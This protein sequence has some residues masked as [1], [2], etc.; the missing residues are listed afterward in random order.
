M[1]TIAGLTVH[2]F[3]NYCCYV[4]CVHVSNFKTGLLSFSKA[5]SNWYFGIWQVPVTL[6]IDTPTMGLEKEMLHH[7][8][9]TKVLCIAALL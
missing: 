6:L 4:K 1:S 2:V 7:I 3:V 8:S 9:L 5:G